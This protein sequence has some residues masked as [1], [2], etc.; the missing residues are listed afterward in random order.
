MLIMLKGSKAA[1]HLLRPAAAVRYHGH[2]A[3]STISWTQT[4]RQQNSIK[5]NKQFAFSQVCFKSSTAVR[6]DD[7]SIDLHT[8]PDREK[9]QVAQTVKGADACQKVGI[10]QL[11]ITQP[12]VLYRNLTFQELFDHEVANNEG[13]VAGGIRRYLH[14]RH[15]Q[16]HGPISQGS[17]D[18]AQSR[19]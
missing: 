11:G 15:G 9:Y 12:N 10:D 6:N 19:Q 2:K 16:I 13:V 4:S 14:R 5:P 17:L 18:C 1:R 8:A 7:S 3:L